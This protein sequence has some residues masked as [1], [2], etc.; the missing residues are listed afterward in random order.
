MLPPSSASS[1]AQAVMVVHI[2]VVRGE[3]GGADCIPL[4]KKSNVRG[5]GTRS[6]FYNPP[7]PLLLGGLFGSVP[8]AISDQ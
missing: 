1:T 4:R 5:G 3:R 7:I 8:E 6:P 2:I